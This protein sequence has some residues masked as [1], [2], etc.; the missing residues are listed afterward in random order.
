MGAGALWWW[1]ARL[2]HING[3]SLFL[4]WH[5]KSPTLTHFHTWFLLED[6][7]CLPW[8]FFFMFLCIRFVLFF[9]FYCIYPP[10]LFLCCIDFLFF[11]F[12]SL[13]CP[14]MDT[15]FN[16][17]RLKKRN[18]IAVQ[19]RVMF[20]LMCCSSSVQTERQKVQVVVCFHLDS[21]F[22]RIGKQNSHT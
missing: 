1:E 18:S 16:M 22:S 5:T 19:F 6:R 15:E 14:L 21:L 12:A 20:V 9:Y 8:V 2:H 10:D 7:G 13:H 3:Q 17:D 11:I 4:C